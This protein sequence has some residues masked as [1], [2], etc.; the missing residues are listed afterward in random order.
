M[1]KTPA[2]VLWDFDGTLIDSEPLWQRA[3]ARIAEEYG[4]T[5]NDELAAGMHGLAW[6]AAARYLLDWVGAG[7]EPVQQ[8]YQRWLDIVPAGLREGVTWV[9][10]ARE[11]LA[12]M[13]AEGITCAVVSASYREILD[14]V[15]D[16][17]PTD[18]FAT[19]IA[20][21]DVTRGKPHPEPYLLAAE[22]LGVDPRDCLVIEDSVGGCEA[23]NAAGA[24]VLAVPS[25]HPVPPAP[26]RVQLPDLAG[27]RWRDVLATTAPA[28]DE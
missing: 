11:L 2:A 20:G 1:T 3:H 24:V 12:E 8:V 15:V 5:W 9:P 10:G 6:P 16:G 14:A 21:D 18:T 19:M 17:M 25:E 7:D 27:V 28:W 23:G 26:R 13:R 22:R 4:G